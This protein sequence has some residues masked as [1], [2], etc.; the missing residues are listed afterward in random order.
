MTH[1]F[2][3]FLLVTLFLAAFTY[4]CPAPLIY[5]AGEGWIYEKVGSKGRWQ[6]GRAQDQLAVAQESFDQKDYSTCL[7]AARRTVAQ[8]PLS[9]YAPRAQY[10]VGRCH[11]AKKM[12]QKAFQDYQKLIEK[13]PKIDNYEEVVGRQFALTTR[14]LNGQW[15][16]L[17][18]FVPFFPSMDKTSDMYEKIIKN[19]P[20]SDFGPRSQLNIGA[21][22][23]KQKDFP[24][25]VQAYETA[26]DR[27]NDQPKIAS[28][29]LYKKG[30]AYNREARTSEYDQNVAGQ[31]IASFTDFVTLFPED[32]RVPDAQKRIGTMRTEQ[33]RGNFE[34]ARF[35]EKRHRWDGALIYYNEVLIKD[36]NSKYA[37][38]AR[39]R[40]DTLKK[41]AKK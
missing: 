8:W 30:V 39:E 26:A 36:P 7:K 27:Y 5:K 10:L 32:P 24:K 38:V 35:Y 13:Y 16:K 31:A 37:A 34:I 11:E 41:R 25:A 33:A 9:D 17:W 2:A 3:R 40:I 29:A 15:F 4:Q 19:G 1:R 14:F 6:R 21:A 23:E 20:Y 22:R 18:G 28:E 12:D